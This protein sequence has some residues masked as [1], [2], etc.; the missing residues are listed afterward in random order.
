MTKN[1]GVL[2]A[3]FVFPLRGKFV[4]LRGCKKYA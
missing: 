2:P 3:F 4:A 1:A